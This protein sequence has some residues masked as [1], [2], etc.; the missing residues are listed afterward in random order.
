M[1]YIATLAQYMALELILGI[2]VG[3]ISKEI[4]K[5]DARKSSNTQIFQTSEYSSRHFGN[6]LPKLNFFNIFNLKPKLVIVHYQEDQMI[7]EDFYTFLGD[8]T[9]A[10]YKN[11]VFDQSYW[12]LWGLPIYICTVV[13]PLL[14]GFIPGILLFF[15]P[16][17]NSFFSYL[18]I[19]GLFWGFVGIWLPPFLYKESY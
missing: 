4:I 8:R 6:H 7:R 11:G 1:N 15:I 5:S 16:S 19:S 2:L 9:T 10:I 17:L 18:F 13:A 3:F 14:I 12:D